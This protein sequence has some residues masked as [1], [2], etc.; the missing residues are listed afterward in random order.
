MPGNIAL[1]LC[2]GL[3]VSI[4]RTLLTESAKVQWYNLRKVPH[5]LQY[6]RFSA[7]NLASMRF[8]LRPDGED[9]H[10]LNEISDE[11]EK[12]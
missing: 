10:R 12:I 11:L 9:R 2:E 1:H 4:F 3:I 6:G 7:E 8:A 5:S